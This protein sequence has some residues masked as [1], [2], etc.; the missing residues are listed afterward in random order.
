CLPTSTR[1]WHSSD[2][3]FVT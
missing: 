3:V 1:D 2:S